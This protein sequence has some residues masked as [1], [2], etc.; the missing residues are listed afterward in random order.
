MARVGPKF[1][2]WCLYKRRRK[3]RERKTHREGHVKTEAGILDKP[4]NVKDCQEA[5]ETWK[6]QGR[7]IPRTCRGSMFAFIYE[8][9]ADHSSITFQ[10]SLLLLGLL[11][12]PHSQG[13]RG[14]QASPRNLLITILS[15]SSLRTLFNHFTCFVL[16][17]EQ[18]SSRQCHIVAL[19]RVWVNYPVQPLHTGHLSK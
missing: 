16:T 17:P 10:R 12:Q 9:S 8:K 4:K 5:P 13:L 3:H 14:L 1:M 19:Y 7:I 15:P 2:N 18:K 6:R 11:Q